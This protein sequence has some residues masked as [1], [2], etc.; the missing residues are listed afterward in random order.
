VHAILLFCLLLVNAAVGQIMR[1]AEASVHSCTSMVDLVHCSSQ[2]Q[3]QAG[4]SC[5]DTREQSACGRH[6]IHCTHDCTLC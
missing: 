6:S 5:I 1:G 3:G 4:H 2:E